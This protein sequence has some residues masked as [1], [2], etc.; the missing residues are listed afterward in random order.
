MRG[1][2]RINTVLPDELLLEIFHHVDSK[3][4]RDTCALVCKRWLSLERLSRESIRIGASASPD[5]R[6]RLLSRCFV[7]IRCVFV[8]ERLSIS[9][10]VHYSALTKT[11]PEMALEKFQLFACSM[12]RSI[13]D[14]RL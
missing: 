13:S 8:D 14:A 9:L 10:P 1:Y 12:Q 5:N 6:V 4:N 7:N 2:D 3:P 11:N